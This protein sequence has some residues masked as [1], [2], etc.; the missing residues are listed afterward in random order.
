MGVQDGP[1]IVSVEFE[2]FGQVQGVYFT[3]YCRDMCVQLGIGGWVKNTKN[4]TIVGKIQGPRIAVEHMVQWLS[5]TGSP[6]AK[7]DR[8]EFKNWEF[9]AR[10]DFR[11]FSIRF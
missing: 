10:Q 7:I 5:K 8:C 9:L 6:G 1:A 2:V 11:G 3:K 4:G